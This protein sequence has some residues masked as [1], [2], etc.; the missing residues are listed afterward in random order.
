MTSA[1]TD[2]F[3]VL[4]VPQACDI[5]MQALEAQY[6]QLQ[7]QWHPDRKAGASDSEKLEAIQRTS[8]LNDAYST[9]KSPLLRAAHLLQLN[10]VDTN[11][12]AQSQLEPAFL[13][14]QMALRDELDDSVKEG[15]IAALQSMHKSVKAGQQELWQSFTTA[16]ADKNFG[17]GQ[18]IFYKMQ[19]MYRLQ[20]E[21]RAAE[22]KL[23]GY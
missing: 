20:E 9:L 18:R 2:F 19:F 7:N 22:D 1:V 10:G 17:Q 12:H 23:L 5:D 13:L 15:N 16:F 21:I 14:S 8:L 4:Q 6:R 3:A 11:S